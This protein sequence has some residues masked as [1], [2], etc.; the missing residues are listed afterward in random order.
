[1]SGTNAPLGCLPPSPHHFLLLPPPP[2]LPTGGS[3][4]SGVAQCVAGSH[5]TKICNIADRS[6]AVLPDRRTY[7]S[8]R[9]RSSL[10]SA[11]R[12]WFCLQR[13]FH[14]AHFFFNYRV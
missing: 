3:A 4:H 6:P 9:R 1:M 8:G 11:P 10:Q 7:A 5:T 13:V 14:D 12:I 2:P